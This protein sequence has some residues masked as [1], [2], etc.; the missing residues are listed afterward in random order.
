M[1]CPATVRIWPAPAARV[2]KEPDN[3]FILVET[4]HASFPEL[5]DALDTGALLRGE[6]L[7]TTRGDAPGE[8]YITQR[9]PIALTRA[10]IARIENCSWSLIDPSAVQAHG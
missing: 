5:L 9:T 1:T 10:G 8:R 3:V 4:D 7:W 6:Q 2:G